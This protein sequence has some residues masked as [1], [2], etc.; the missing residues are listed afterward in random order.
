MVY[1]LKVVGMNDRTSLI[2]LEN[3]ALF[4][5]PNAAQ[6]RETPSM[7]VV[8]MLKSPPVSCPSKTDLDA[9]M[10]ELMLHDW[11]DDA[12][13]VPGASNRLNLDT[14]KFPAPPNPEET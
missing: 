1:F 12:V 3:I 11:E 13:I 10:D 5:R 4:D 8:I 7:G 2:P 6:R 14:L 9:I